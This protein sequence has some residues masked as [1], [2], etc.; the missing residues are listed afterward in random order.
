MGLLSVPGKLLYYVSR[1]DQHIPLLYNIIA[2]AYYITYY[3]GVFTA[4]LL[5]LP[6]F[7]PNLLFFIRIIVYD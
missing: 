6:R 7:C 5:G 1:S 4:L 3:F 2:K